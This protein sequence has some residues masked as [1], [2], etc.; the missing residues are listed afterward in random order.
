MVNS[1][2]IIYS[3]GYEIDI[4]SH[5]FPTSK[6][7]LIKEFLIKNFNLQENDFV[8]PEIAAPSMVMQV[9]T[10]KYVN[11]IKN[12]TLSY[13]DE[14]RLELPYSEE[15][16]RASLLCCAG[17]VMACEIALENGAGVHL[18]GGFHHAYPDHGE[19]FCV[20]NDV[21]IGAAQMLKK[22]KK[23]LVVDC[24]LHQGNGTAFIFKDNPDV[25]TFSM[26]QQ[27]NYPLYKEK[28]DIDVPLEDGTNGSEY[29]RLLLNSLKNIEG[30]FQPDFIIYVAGSDTYK[31][32]Q[33]G[34]LALTIEDLRDRDCIVK[35]EC[36]TGV[37]TAVVLA[38][39]YAK[40][41]EDTVSIHSN[42]VI[43]FL[44]L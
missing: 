12:G 21:A 35:S 11:D 28:S 2:K 41:I 26:H 13:A 33:L 37:P 15:L 29:N 5:V 31:D 14:I 17:T 6:Y 36:G 8:S 24:D 20:F 27:N 30:R 16:A 38:G 39:G 22:G 10:Q 9:H 23:V 44:E 43:T 40:R 18:G 3:P 7:R 19:G 1:R 34:G 32:D 4:G 25:F 42:T